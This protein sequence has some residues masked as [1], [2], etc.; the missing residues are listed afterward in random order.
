ML[1]KVNLAVALQTQVVPYLQLL[2]HPIPRLL[3]TMFSQILGITLY[4]ETQ[5]RP[6]R[7]DL[8]IN[9]SFPAEAAAEHL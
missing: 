8:I 7:I 4:R 3:A 1:H 9:G 2:Q 6:G 5:P